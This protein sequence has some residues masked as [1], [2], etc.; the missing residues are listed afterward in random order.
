MSYPIYESS[1]SV[2]PTSIIGEDV[3][4]GKNNYIGPFCIIEDNVIIGD[5]NRIESNSVIGSLPEHKEYF[6][7]GTSFG[8]RIGNNNTVREFTTINA[9]TI[10]N[11]II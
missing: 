5:N 1:N 3:F 2:H 11:T 6:K 4:I 8:V 10:Q 9:G 7:T